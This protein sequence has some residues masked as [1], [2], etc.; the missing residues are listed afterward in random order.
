LPR[1][2]RWWRNGGKTLLA[3]TGLVNPAGLAIGRDGSFSVSNFGTFPGSD[4]S[5]QLPGTGQVVRIQRR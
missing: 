4:P 3:S 2:P 1:R 5:H